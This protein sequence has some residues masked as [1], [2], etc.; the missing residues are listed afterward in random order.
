MPESLTL[1][2]PHS[3]RKSCRMT[4][5]RRPRRSPWRMRSSPNQDSL[6][7]SSGSPMESLL[8]NKMFSANPESIRTYRCGFWRRYCVV[9]SS[10][11][12]GRYPRQLVPRCCPITRDDADVRDLARAA[13]YVSS[14]VSGQGDHWQDAGYWLIPLIALLSALWFRPGWMVSTS[15]LS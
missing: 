6:A 13:K 11:F 14:T 5:T 4:A 7:R 12:S 2:P 8:T 10:I 15:A 3:I 9:R 1:L